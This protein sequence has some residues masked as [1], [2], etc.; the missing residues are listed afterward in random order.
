MVA[1]CWYGSMVVWWCGGGGF[2][3]GLVTIINT[4]P[5]QL[6]SLLFTPLPF[7]HPVQHAGFALLF[8]TEALR[9]CS[10][11]STQRV[12]ATVQHAGFTLL[13]GTEALR[14]RLLRST[15]RVYAT[16]Q[17]RGFALPSP[18]ST[19][20]KS[21]SVPTYAFSSAPKVSA[22]LQP[23]VVSILALSKSEAPH[24]CPPRTSCQTLSTR[25]PAF[26]SAP[27]VSACL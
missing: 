27:K 2:L 22:R 9:F 7:T 4:R 18:R 3:L 8:D 25:T 19:N 21:I 10:P 17:H 23:Y 26:S 24:R 1:F 14:Y 16:V 11:G 6:S 13:F 12:Y 20:H 15:H 5:P